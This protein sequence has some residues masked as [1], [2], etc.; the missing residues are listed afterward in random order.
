MEKNRS[1]LTSRRSALLLEVLFS[2]GLCAVV[3]PSLLKGPLLLFKGC[4]QQ[5]LLLELQRE[6]DV[7]LTQAQGDL[8]VYPRKPL[9]EHLS[10]FQLLLKPPG[11]PVVACVI[12]LDILERHS[13]PIQVPWGLPYHLEMIGLQATVQ[14]RALEYR[15]MQTSLFLEVHT[16]AVHP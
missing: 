15:R 16:E 6:V 8:L 9:S 4:Q 2:M 13:F 12:S 14:D 11:R 5:I 7:R 3:L 1:R 10:S